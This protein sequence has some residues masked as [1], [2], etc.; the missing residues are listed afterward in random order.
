MVRKSLWGEQ[1]L[2]TTDEFL[3]KATDIGASNFRPSRFV[4]QVLVLEFLAPT[5]KGKISQIH[6]INSK[7][8]KPTAFNTVVLDAVGLAYRPENVQ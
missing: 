3:T 7:H 5:E 8:Y 2:P 4:M 1:H 6:E